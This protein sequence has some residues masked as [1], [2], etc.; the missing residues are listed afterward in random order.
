MVRMSLSGK[1][2]GLLSRLLKILLRM[3]FWIS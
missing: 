3:L 2:L 1:N